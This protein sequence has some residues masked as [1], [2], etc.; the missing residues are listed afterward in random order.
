MN[1][2]YYVGARQNVG[3]LVAERTFVS[4]VYAWMSL[5]LVATALVAA[6][7]AFNPKL[8][9]LII[10]NQFMFFG[11]I[12]AELLLVMAIGGLIKSMSSATAT[13]LFIAYSILN[14]LTLSVIFLAY[15]IGSVATVFF[16]CAGLFGTM[17]AVG[18]MTKM[19]LTSMG[20]LLSMAVI[21]LVVAMLVNLFLK[22]NMMDLI[23]SAIGVL[24]FVGLTAYDA[25]KI[26]LMSNASMDG[27]SERKAAICGALALYLDFINL[28]LF[29]LR[30]FGRR[31]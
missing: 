5:G 23:V 8:A 15:T 30:L 28:F 31:R 3:T 9:R 27:E 25:Q 29:L 14:G 4:K 2:S 12:I 22:S 7:V 1:E 19:D 26:K 18:F 16:I 20:G 24:V 11:I 10:G 21:G 6:Y 13:A 17:S